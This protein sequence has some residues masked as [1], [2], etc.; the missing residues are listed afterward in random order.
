MKRGLFVLGLALVAMGASVSTAASPEPVLLSVTQEHRHIVA[1]FTL[2]EFAPGQIQIATRLRMS[3]SGA[4][5]RANV[6]LRETVAAQPEPATGL[7]RWRTRAALPARTYYVQVSGF[8]TGG[9]TSCKPGLLGCLSLQHWS[10][11]RRVVVR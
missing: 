5:L 6:K 1:S 10:N 11:V 3:P 8:E 9:V 4:F 7:V 2:G